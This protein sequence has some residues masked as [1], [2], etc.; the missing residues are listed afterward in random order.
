MLLKGIRVIA[1]IM[2]TS[3]NAVAKKWLCS[4]N[5]MA[6]SITQDANLS[7]NISSLFC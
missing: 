7:C 3:L 6:S 5:L 2:I 1:E 4:K